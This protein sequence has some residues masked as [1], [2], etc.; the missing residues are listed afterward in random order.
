[1]ER[2]ENPLK[3]A[4]IGGITLFKVKLKDKPNVLWNSTE[5]CYSSIQKPTFI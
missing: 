3:N 2:L 5:M 1:M 4:P